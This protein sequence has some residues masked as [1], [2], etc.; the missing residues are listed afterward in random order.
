MPTECNFYDAIKCREAACNTKGNKTTKLLTVYKMV[1]QVGTVL[2]CVV[3]LCC[4]VSYCC[5]DDS[6]YEVCSNM[7]C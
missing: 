2:Y 3:V 1:V 6:D 4:A 5:S 7:K